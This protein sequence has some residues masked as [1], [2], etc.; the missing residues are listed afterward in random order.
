MVVRS[1]CTKLKE[2][3]WYRVEREREIMSEIIKH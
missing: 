2:T 3:G 1:E